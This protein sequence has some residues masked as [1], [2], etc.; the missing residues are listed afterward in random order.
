MVVDLV[1]FIWCVFDGDE[2]GS[3]GWMRIDGDVGK[4]RPKISPKL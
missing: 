1:S 3:T 2:I 4:V